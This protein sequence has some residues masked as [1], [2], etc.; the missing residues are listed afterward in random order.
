[1]DSLRLTIVDYKNILQFYNVDYTN[2]TYNNI[3]KKASELIASNL[4]KC[5]KKVTKVNKFSSEQ[6]AIAICTNSILKKH[7]LKYY[8]F[9][10]GKA[11]KLKPYY[12]NDSLKNTLVHTRLMKQTPGRLTYSVKNTR[13]TYKSL[14]QRKTRRVIRR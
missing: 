5:I 2:M 10:C 1:M 8:G 7:N 3:K 12:K 14:K 13:R 4:C 11:P 9:S 6:P